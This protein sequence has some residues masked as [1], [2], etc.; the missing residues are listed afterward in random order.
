MTRKYILNSYNR[1]LG[2]SSAPVFQFQKPINANSVYVSKVNFPNSFYNIVEEQNDRIFWVASV[3]NTEIQSHLTTGNYSIDALL[4]EI[5]NQMT[6]DAIT[7]DGLVYTAT[8][9]E[10]TGKVTIQ[11]ST[12]ANFTIRLNSAAYPIQQDEKCAN[13]LM[14]QLGFFT[15]PEFGSD[16]QG[17][18]E[19][20]GA[21]IYTANNS[22]YITPSNIYLTSS[23]VRES[24]NYTSFTL[25]N[26]CDEFTK[27]YTP[28]DGISNILLNVPI[29]DFYGDCTLWECGNVPERLSLKKDYS[30][31]SIGFALMDSD[32]NLPI[33]LNGRSFTVELVFE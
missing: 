28:K 20:T 9:D 15:A 14:Y 21:G 25:Y 10:L 29:T 16:I 4:T 1:S 27:L 31:S 33:S 18:T 6:N 12:N 26:K 23:L 19:L 8:R 11:N 17:V 2:T 30:I 5:S 13:Y 7:E 22:Y 24:I 32:T 3:G